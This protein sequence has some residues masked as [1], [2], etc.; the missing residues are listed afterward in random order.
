MSD[1]FLRLYKKYTVVDS[2]VAN[3]DKKDRA[4]SRNWL[5]KKFFLDSMLDRCITEL[6]KVTKNTW[7]IKYFLNSKYL[8]S[9]LRN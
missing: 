4:V 8:P 7:S 3:D 6:D 9:N 1:F 5:V 2:S